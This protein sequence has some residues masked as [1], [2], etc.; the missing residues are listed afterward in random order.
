VNSDHDD[1]RIAQVEPM[2]S[3]ILRAGVIA[4]LAL[5]I[6][7]TIISFVRHPEYTSDPGALGH[8]VSPGA[9]FPSTLS[10]L[11]HGLS[12]LRG[13]AIVILGLLVLIATPAVR[14]A[15]SILAFYRLRDWTYVAITATVLVLLL[16]SFVLN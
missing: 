16:L 10:E 6:A 7:G 15:V 1:P 12:N 4:S 5:L 9:A 14:V 8:L 2:I 11:L 3:W 13:Q